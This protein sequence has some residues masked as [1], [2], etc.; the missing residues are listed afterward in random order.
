[1]RLIVI[2]LMFLGSLHASAQIYGRYMSFGPNEVKLLIEND[3]IFFITPEKVSED[4]YIDTDIVFGEEVW[5]A[6]SYEFNNDTILFSYKGHNNRIALIDTFSVLLVDSIE[7]KLDENTLFFCNYR[8][9]MNRQSIFSGHWKNGRKHGDW[10]YYDKQRINYYW[11][12]NNGELVD[13]IKLPET[14]KVYL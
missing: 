2:V 6:S 9:D 8:C 10:R 5:C 14:I 3:T 12:Y 4:F 7:G 13:T 1:M 11:R